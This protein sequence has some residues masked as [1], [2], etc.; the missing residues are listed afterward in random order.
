[1]LRYV[2]QYKFSILLTI[3]IVVL[4][5]L[6]AS[7]FPFDSVYNIPH[8]DKFVHI[9]MYASLGFVALLECRCTTRCHGQY[10]L[11]L[12]GILLASVLIEIV[13][14]TLIASRGAEWFD[15]VANSLG[16]SAAYIAFRLFGRWK[17]S[18]FLDPDTFLSFPEFRN[19]ICNGLCG[20]N[21][22]HLL[23]GW[24]HFM[25]YTARML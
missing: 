2:I 5:L 10:F 25:M 12:L 11:V 6:P 15:L 20:K 1:M 24:S 22:S 4:S 21:A 18:V 3:V 7:D 8:I 23:P 19:Q 16:L 9:S 17:F 14:A 13:Q